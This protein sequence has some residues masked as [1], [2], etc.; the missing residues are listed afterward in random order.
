MTCS[1]RKKPTRQNKDGT[2][3]ID[4]S[5]TVIISKASKLFI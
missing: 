3:L 4:T 2:A 5:L 1:F